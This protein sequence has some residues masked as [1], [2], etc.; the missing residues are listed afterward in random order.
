MKNQFYIP[1]L[2]LLMLFM[3]AA[4]FSQAV[5]AWTQDITSAPDSAYMFPVATQHDGF[6]NIYVLSTYQDPAGPGSGT[7]KIYLN[8]YNSAG[9]LSWNLIYDHNGVGSPRGFNMTVDD[10]GNCYVA[11]GLMAFP[12]EKPLLIKV[13]S[14]GN[15]AWER[16]STVSFKTTY[17]DQV[18]FKNNRLFVKAWNGIAMFGLDGTEIWSQG[19]PS[20]YMAVDNA[21]Q[22]I[23]SVMFGNP[24]NL[25]RFDSTGTLDFADTTINAERITTDNNNNFYLLSDDNGYELVKYDSAGNFSWLINNFPPITGFGDIGFDVLT[26]Y[27]NDVL[28]VGLN[29]TMYKFTP[30]GS[31]IW[32][33]SMLGL[34][35]YLISAEIAFTNFLGVAGTIPAPNGYDIQVSL[36]NLNGD[37]IWYGTYNSNT[38]QEFAVGL[39]IDNEG[40]YVLEDS[41]SNSA[42]LK[43]ESP[44]FN[45]PLDF[46]L[47]CVDSVWYDPSNPNI[48]NVTVFNGNFNGINY[49]V[50]QIVSPAGDTISNP[51]GLLSFFVHMGN[52][53]L[54]YT[55]SITDSTITNFSNYTFLITDGI[56]DTTV[57]IT[58][59][60]T[61]GTG[62]LEQ[63]EIKIFPNPVSD[64]LFIG[65]DKTGA[66]RSMEVYNLTGACVKKVALDQS[67]VVSV[68]I[69][70]FSPGLYFIR[71]FDSKK[72]LKGKFI[73]N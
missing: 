29:D 69:S 46:S 11:G 43:F 9:D 51:N 39:T 72:V 41:I 33:K 63:A 50:V 24:T 65:F 68:D 49:P 36:Y 56:L 34:D 15:V 18:Y 4:A 27:N 16:D 66:N 60:G 71:I 1:A 28:V 45:T 32:K 22:T 61:T 2:F 53:Y 31:E 13:D 73:K 19:V 14:T 23:V 58:W 64:N 17:Y 44:S 5:P 20:A 6:N 54:T 8:R 25:M 3:P 7:F 42:L 55:D 38:T 40:I 35:N 62:E 21:G 48:I 26:D 47:V 30:S 59:C 12:N 67:A 37:Q 57:E 52:I 10:L 70:G